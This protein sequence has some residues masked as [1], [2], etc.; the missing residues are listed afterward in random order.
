MSLNAT[1]FAVTY[2]PR[3]SY[4]ARQKGTP[5][6]N[7]DVRLGKEWATQEELCTIVAQQAAKQAEALK[8]APPRTKLSDTDIQELAEKYDPNS[9]T[10][11]QYDA[12]LKELVDK[13]VLTRDEIGYMGYKGVSV[14]DV[15][16][17]R[18]SE[19]LDLND[20]LVRYW[21]QG[22]L[23]SG[24][25]IYGSL[26]GDDN[27]AYDVLSWAKMMDTYFNNDTKSRQGYYGAM[28]NVLDRMNS[29]CS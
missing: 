5:D 2:T 13:G 1:D 28:Y 26:L 16:M 12:F 15:N 11:E 3:V 9:M 25:P 27:G 7:V 24:S 17:K 6:S 19:Q 22:N 14:I 23:S 10:Q 29:T 18:V 20:P 8:N 21:M 4:T